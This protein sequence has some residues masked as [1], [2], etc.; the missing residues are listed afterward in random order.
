MH[1]PYVL[2]VDELS[3]DKIKA[4]VTNSASIFYNINRINFTR[5]V[6]YIPGLLADK[7]N[8]ISIMAAGKFLC[9]I[10][11]PKE[12]NSPDGMIILN[13]VGEEEMAWKMSGKFG[14]ETLQ[15]KFM[16]VYEGIIN[17][18]ESHGK[19]RLVIGSTAGAFF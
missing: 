15:K 16:E 7:T 12:N 13:L 8:G 6:V 17:H 14:N 19:F 11:S 10:I 1:E 2:Y 18:P 3:P 4:T 5:P 9:M